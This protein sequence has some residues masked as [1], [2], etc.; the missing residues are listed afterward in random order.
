MGRLKSGVEKLNYSHYGLPVY[1][2]DGVEWAYA[3]TDA[4]AYRACRAYIYD[5]V[6]AFNADFLVRYMP[7]GVTKEVVEA[8]QKNGSEDANEPIFAML[9]NKRKFLIEA[10]SADGRGH[11]LSGYDGHERDSKEV[12]GLPKKGYAYR[13]G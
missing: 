10:I 2:V 8:I 12:E 3:A 4:A 7:K 13:V 11:F 1:K 9:R 6:W 5:T